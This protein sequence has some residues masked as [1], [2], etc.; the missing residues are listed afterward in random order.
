MQNSLGEK[1]IKMQN[2]FYDS[3]GEG[4]A[5]HMD[6]RDIASVAVAALTTRGHEGRAYELTGPQLLSNSDVASILSSV[7]WRTGTQWNGDVSSS[8]PFPC[9]AFV[10]LRDATKRSCM[11]A[12]FAARP[13]L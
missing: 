12:S 5:S 13:R 11:P 1:T 8:R 4:K 2:V 9:R 7:L 10:R 3:A 6:T